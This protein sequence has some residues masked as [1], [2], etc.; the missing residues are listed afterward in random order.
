MFQI[1]KLRSDPVI[2]FAAEELRKYLRMMQP[3]KDFGQIR[4]DADA[5][6]G[7]RL[8][9]LEDFDLDAGD[10][11]RLWD[12]VVHID[13]TEDGGILAGS[14]PRS[15]LFAVYRLLKL[16]DCRF[17]FPGAEGEVIPCQPLKPQ[18]Y[19]KLADHRMRGH[20]IEGRPSYEEVLDYLDFHAKE[21]LNAF[22]CF[23]VS[24][25]HHYHY[26]HVQ[27]DAN[28]E[29][30]FFDADLANSQWRARYEY[31][32]KRRG[33]LLLSGEHE[34]TINALGLR[35][36]DR[37]AY[38]SGKKQ[39]PEDVLPN[40]AQI[41]GVRKIYRNDIFC[42][43]LCMS[44][45]EL[46]TKMVNAVVAEI[47]KKPYLDFYGVTVADGAR[48]HCECEACQQKIPSDWYV[49]VLNELDEVLTQKGLKNR[50]IFSFYV[51]MIFA[52]QTESLK[53]PD[54]FIL[55]YCPISRTY[56][57]SIKDVSV[58]PEPV[59]YVRNAWTPPKSSEEVFSLFKKWQEVFPGPYSV[60]EYHFWVHQYRDPG[61]MAM[62]RRIYEDVQSYK[63]T[64]M[65]GCMQDGS[66]KSFWPNGFMGHIY[67]ES[68]LNRN[69]DY[70]AELKDY[71]SRFYGKDWQVARDYLQAI[72]DAFDHSY[73]C[74][75]KSAEKKHGEHYNPDH[76]QSL[77]KVHEIT[78][79]LRK[80]L[81]TKDEPQ[82]RVEYLGWRLLSEH[83][84]Y[85]DGIAR[86]MTEKCLGNTKAAVDTAKK[87]FLEFGKRQG[88]LA[89][90][91][92]MELAIQSIKIIAEKAPEIE[93]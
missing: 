21:E 75:R 88:K 36:E 38:R 26:N 66:N 23:G 15:V 32:A 53:N 89:R 49:M 91:L 19:H 82:S 44:R 4:L 80:F 24:I 50:I 47:E 29:P 69:C 57:S 83:A 37:F 8:G 86:I 59:K 56:D 72:S 61:S 55:Q 76:A 10:I 30:E 42:T 33:L 87:F 35:I 34:M 9:L 22:G 27:N 79:G 64:D 14:N 18:K 45:P 1:N 17:F 40:V 52:P 39:I 6:D 3:E 65:D 2:D 74:G 77:A 16:N 54:R 71:Y 5:K 12:D 62:S 60:Y 43:N 41:K 31:E 28:C 68:L 11:D 90:W 67:A 78:D 73:M 25:Y 70:D 84:D 13:T 85:C 7:F 63:L 58:L 51:D 20:T 81:E 93:L 46:R 92:D 48:N